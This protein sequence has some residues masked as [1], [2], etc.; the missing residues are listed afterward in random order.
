[1]QTS[2]SKP[3]DDLQQ[4][5][6]DLV[7]DLVA[8]VQALPPVGSDER[9]RLGRIFDRLSEDCAEGAA[10]VRALPGRPADRPGHTYAALAAVITAAEAEHD[11]GGWLADLLCRA[12]AHFGSADHLVM[13]RSGSWEA[14]QVTALVLGTAGPMPDDLDRFKDAAQ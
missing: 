7:S 10:L 13:G 2:S 3:I 14:Q 4:H 8:A 6:Q 1:M 9:H 11:F 12:A 5:A